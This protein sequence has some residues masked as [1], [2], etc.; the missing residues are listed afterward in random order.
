MLNIQIR[1]ITQ[2]PGKETAQPKRSTFRVTYS[3]TKK[4]LEF[5]LSKLDYVESSL[6]LEMWVD[7]KLIR[8]DGQL[9]ADARVYKHGVILRFTRKMNR[10]WDAKRETY[11]YTP[12]QLSYPCDAFDSWDDNLRAITLSLE[13]LRKVERYGVFK[14]DEIVS[15]LALPTGEGSTTTRK[16]AAAFLATH[17]GVGMQEILD[18]ETALNAAFKRA[19]QKLHPDYG[20]S[21][22]EF[23][24]LTEA[25]KAFA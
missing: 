1:P 2:W 11:V 4:D 3:R 18:S 19:A 16:D 20:G 6:V 12:Q 13:A 24:K 22:E 7:Q 14:Y 21:H 15:R 25:R 9:R 23:L 8:Q 5:E 17:S 10:R